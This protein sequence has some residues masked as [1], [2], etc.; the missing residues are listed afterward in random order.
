MSGVRRYSY[1]DGNGERRF[2]GSLSQPSGY[3]LLWSISDMDFGEISWELFIF[4]ENSLEEMGIRRDAGIFGGI[5]PLWNL[6]ECFLRGF[7]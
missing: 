1:A 7:R 4:Q 6:P 5:N 3:L 2:F